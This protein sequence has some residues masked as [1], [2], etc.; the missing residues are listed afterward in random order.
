MQMAASISEPINN[1]LSAVRLYMTTHDS[2]DKVGDVDWVVDFLPSI[3]EL[4]LG[5]KIKDVIDGLWT[6]TNE[7]C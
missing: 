4:A 2:L 3:G 6:Q 7:N 1:N 5:K